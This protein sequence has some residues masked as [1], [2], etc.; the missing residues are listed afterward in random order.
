MG[1][2]RDVQTHGDAHGHADQAAGRDDQRA[3]FA[4]RD[5]LHRA[6]D[7]GFEGLKG[8]GSIGYLAI[9]PMGQKLRQMGHEAFAI[10]RDR[11]AMLFVQKV[12]HVEIGQLVET[13]ILYDLDIRGDAFRCFD[14]AAQGAAIDP[15]ES[16]PA[17][18]EMRAQPSGLLPAQVAELVIG[19]LVPR[20]AVGLTVP[21][22]GDL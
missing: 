7:A 9:A 4:R 14:M 22:Q 17:V 16:F 21:N 2:C 20:C 10:L 8:F 5:L 1:H 11:D 13:L 15:L 6:V 3:A 18:A 12:G 19:M